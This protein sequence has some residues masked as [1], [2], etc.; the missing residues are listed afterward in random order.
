MQPSSG[1][2]LWSCPTGPPGP[3][4][5]WASSFLC[6]ECRVPLERKQSKQQPSPLGSGNSALSNRSI[7]SQGPFKIILSWDVLYTNLGKNGGIMFVTESTQIR[8]RHFS[9]ISKASPR[10][11]AIG[12]GPGHNLTCWMGFSWGFVG[13]CQSG[14]LGKGLCFVLEFQEFLC[15]TAYLPCHWGLTSS[16]RWKIHFR[17]ITFLCNQGL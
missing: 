1:M 16:A 13:P 17:K 9:F 6:L 2:G 11:A 7:V 10:A 3:M 5:F 14:L 4:G 12:A 8:R 15:S